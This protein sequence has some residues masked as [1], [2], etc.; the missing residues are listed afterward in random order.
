MQGQPNLKVH[1]LHATTTTDHRHSLRICFATLLRCSSCGSRCHSKTYEEASVN[2]KSGA[3]L[4]L[5]RHSNLE[6]RRSWLPACLEATL[7]SDL[8]QTAGNEVFPEQVDVILERSF[9]ALPH[10]EKGRV[11]TSAT[12]ADHGFGRSADR[13]CLAQHPRQPDLW[14]P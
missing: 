1:V 3:F 4:F 9:C 13:A 14:Q 5:P 2:S 12:L 10:Q 6:S 7:P 11:P 8:C